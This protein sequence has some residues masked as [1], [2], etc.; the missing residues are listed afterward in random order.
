[1]KS[2]NLNLSLR[3]PASNGSQ[4]RATVE[5]VGW[6]VDAPPTGFDPDYPPSAR[7]AR[8][9]FYGSKRRVRRSVQS[10]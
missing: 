4:D 8:R 9:V 3:F 10:I 5:V 1:M 6:W 2:R 7:F